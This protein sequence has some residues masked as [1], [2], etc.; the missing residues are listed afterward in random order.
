MKEKNIHKAIDLYF[1]AQLSMAEEEDLFQ[2]LLVFK[3]H[4]RKVDEALAVMLMARMPMESMPSGLRPKK[5]RLRMSLI[6][7][8]AGALIAI[9]CISALWRRTVDADRNTDRNTE[10]MIAYVGGVKISDQS[11]IMRIVDDQLN[12]IG[13][14]SELFARTIAEDLDDISDAFNEADL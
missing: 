9:V 4:D 10:G 5:T 6:Y 11:E 2:T 8:A 13:V 1:D 3:G 7:A 14:S 12:D